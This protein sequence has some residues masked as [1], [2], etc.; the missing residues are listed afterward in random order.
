VVAALWLAVAVLAAVPGE[1]YMA[2]Y[3][4]AVIR[5]V[6]LIFTAVAL[7]RVLRIATADERTFWSL[8]SLGLLFKFLADRSWTSVGVFG[9]APG[10]LTLRNLAFAVSHAILVAAL[11]RVRNS[12]RGFSPN[13]HLPGA[14]LDVVSKPGRGITVQVRFE[15][16]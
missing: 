9:V 6:V 5:L 4:T 14:G 13:G 1:D 15:R 10:W 2:G 11:L 7:V 3:F 16:R 8:V 12:R